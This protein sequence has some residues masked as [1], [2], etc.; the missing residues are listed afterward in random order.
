MKRRTWLTIGALSILGCGGTT[1]PK[2][3]DPGAVD[4]PG[5]PTSAATEAAQADYRKLP[6]PAGEVRWAPPAP[7]ISKLSNGMPVYYSKQG[8]VP[9]VTLMLVLPRGAA[10]DP[11]GK[12]GL[13]ALTVDLLDE[14]AGGK[15]ALEL[16]EELQRLGTD[17]GGRADV[18][19]VILVMNTITENLRPSAELLAAIARKPELSVAEFQRRKEQR[20]A[21]ALSAEA[22]PGYGRDVVLRKAL[23]A[24]G[25]G[26]QLASGTRSSLKRITHA[27]V[28]AHYAKLIAPQGAALIAVGGIDRQPLRS[29][30]EA[31]F[32]DWQG[33]A[34][35]K[36]ASAGSAQP[37]RAIYFVDYPDASQSA[38]A[39]G[40]RAEGEHS[41]DY[42][43]ALVFNRAFGEAFTSRLNLN[44]REDKGYTYGARSS[45]VRWDPIGYFVLA[46]SVKAETT[47]PSIDEM[48]GELREACGAR[49]LAEKERK[50]AVDGLLLGLPGRFERITDVAAQFVPLPLYGRD[51]E[52]LAKW[53]ERV[54]GID[55]DG[56]NALAKKYCDPGEFVIVVAGDK[57]SVA[58]TLQGLELPVHYYDAQG[59]KL[60][61]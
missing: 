30:L 58:P 17:F 4:A 32:G 49:P 38:V 56:A 18:D 40:R 13:T 19:N 24:G 6:G 35:A 52:W 15:S 59:R 27:D 8:T 1:P 54:Q 55:L 44:L 10:T 34:S 11:A 14:G 60:G 36:P 28:K 45:F 33:V 7:E 23:F 21:E 41:P 61:K 3:A 48:L 9:L 57:K 47:R 25:Y 2:S 20:L 53:P 39:V 46:A 12:A 43:P 51:P 37:E 42:F 5:G 31:A 50:Q 16:S 26:G 29:A 22:E